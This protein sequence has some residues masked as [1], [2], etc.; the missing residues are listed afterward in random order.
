MIPVI[1]YVDDEPEALQAFSIAFADEFRILTTSVPSDGLA[2]LCDKSNHIA[3]VIADQ[4]MPGITGLEFLERARLSTPG[5]LRYLVAAYS[6]MEVLVAAI[7]SGAVHHYIEKP[8]DVES[9]YELLKYSVELW[10]NE[11]FPNT[12]RIEGRFH[13]RVILNRHGELL[14]RPQ[15]L[16]V[17]FN[18]EP[19]D[20]ET[21]EF[22]RAIDEQGSEVDPVEIHYKSIFH[23][24][25]QHL[26]DRPGQNSDPAC[27]A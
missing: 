10:G 24:L 18:L 9:L 16:T 25:K 23:A 15:T 1:L 5:A 4:R 27:G 22:T 3:V 19:S 8:W 11:P 14:P 20:L 2:M 17:E 13:Q 12:T 26:L 21:V 6:D 7:N